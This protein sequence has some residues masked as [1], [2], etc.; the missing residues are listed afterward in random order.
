VSEPCDAMGD[1]WIDAYLAFRRAWVLGETTQGDRTASDAAAVETPDSPVGRRSRA[2]DPDAHSRRPTV[3]HNQ[4]RKAEV[5]HA[6]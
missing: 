4:L 3:H 5:H 6:C 2:A 1:P